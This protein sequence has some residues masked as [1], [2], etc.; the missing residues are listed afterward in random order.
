MLCRLTAAYAN[1]ADLILFEGDATGLNAAGFVLDLVLALG[2]AAP[3]SADKAGLLLCDLKELIIVMSVVCTVL[4][5]LLCA[6]VDLVVNQ[7]GR[8]HV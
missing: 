3:H 8:A 5:V 6:S 7:I 1:V 4:Q 2:V